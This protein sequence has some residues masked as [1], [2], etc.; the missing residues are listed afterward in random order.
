MSKK[1]F[2]T[3]RILWTG[4]LRLRHTMVVKAIKNSRCF[5][6]VTRTGMVGWTIDHAILATSEENS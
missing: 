1:N 2:G 4:Y 3:V 5:C 6:E